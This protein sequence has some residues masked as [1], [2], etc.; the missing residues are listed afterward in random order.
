MPPPSQWM[1][2]DAGISPRASAPSSLGAGWSPWS[3]PSFPFLLS[4]H[5]FLLRSSIQIRIFLLSTQG[6]LPVFTWSSVRTAAI[7]DILDASVE[8]GVPHFH[9]PLHHLVHVLERSFPF[10]LVTLSSPHMFNFCF[11]RRTQVSSTLFRS[12]GHS[13]CP[14]LCDPRDFSMPGFPVHP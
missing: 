9:L 10:Y 4:L 7:L 13:L 11:L 5:P 6:V 8:R 2:M 14:T 12:V 3:P 1:A